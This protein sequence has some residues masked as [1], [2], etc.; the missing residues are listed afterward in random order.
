MTMGATPATVSERRVEILAI[1]TELFAARGFATTT[2]RDIADAAGILSG[3]LYHHFD[4]KES[5]V[6]EILRRFLEGVLD[7]YRRAIAKG[8]DP[9]ATLGALVHIAF[10]TLVTHRAE[11]TVM[12]NENTMLSQF[13]RFSFL[14]EASEETERLWVSVLADGVRAGVFRRDIEPRMMYRFMRDSIWSVRWYRPHEEY[15]PEDIAPFY[16]DML[17]S[18]IRVP[19]RGA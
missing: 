16:V 1:A 12:M 15:R 18:G 3:S 6:D 17:L 2:V 7:R 14:R 9:V 11:V 5:M 10:D 13:P 8:D 19:E 4:S